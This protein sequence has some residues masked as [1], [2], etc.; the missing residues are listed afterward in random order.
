MLSGDVTR[1]AS[2]CTIVAPLRRTLKR[3]LLRVIAPFLGVARVNARTVGVARANTRSVG[4]AR[5]L[6]LLHIS[7]SLVV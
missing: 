5:L 4:V 7:S 2:R 1:R 3:Q 6:Y